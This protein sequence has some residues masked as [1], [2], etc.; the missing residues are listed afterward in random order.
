MKN[1]VTAAAWAANITMIAMVVMII[2]DEYMASFHTF[3]TSLTGHHWV[4]KSVFEVVFFIVLFFILGMVMKV[5][6][7][8]PMKGVL[9]AVVVGVVSMAVLFGFF[10][11]RFLGEYGH[12]R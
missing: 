7:K 4:T 5:D 10:L 1:K 6:K 9:S 11:F 2:L 8:R 3:L 12:L